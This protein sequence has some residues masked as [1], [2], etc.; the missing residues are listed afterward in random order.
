MA[1]RPFL[2]AGLLFFARTLKMK[3]RS[4]I[5]N[6][7]MNK[8][9]RLT[10]T[11]MFCTVAYVVMFAVKISGIG[12]FLT[13]DV[14]DAI[15]ASGAM[16]LGPVSG[17]VISLIVSLLE[18]ITVSNTGYWGA[19]MNFIS[20]AVFASVASAI[21]NYMPKIKKK[22]SG[23]WTGLGASIFLTL[24][25]MIIMNLVIT[26]IYLKTDVEAVA[27]MILPLLL[28]FNLI[29]V[30]LNSSIVMIIYKPI[31]MMCKRIGMIKEHRQG[32]SDSPSYFSRLTLIIFIACALTA[33]ICIWILLGKFNGSFSFA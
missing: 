7:R 23:A 28:P 29:K 10:L 16:M 20:S 33:G 27:G 4:S 13:L 6:K 21:Y 8:I 2:G 26:P 15:I 25:V 31:S 30:V 32:Q 22:V 5:M 3:G 1:L 18:L 24:A 19:V 17:V 11:A 12:G 14:K 9:N